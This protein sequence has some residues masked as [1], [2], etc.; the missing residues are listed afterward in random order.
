M[1]EERRRG[2]AGP[3]FGDGRG[4]L[5]LGIQ[6]FREI[7]ESGAYYVDKTAYAHR[8]ITEGK[9]YF[10]SRPRRFGK[11]LL[12]DMLRELFEG[13]EELFEGLSIHRR[14]DW[15]VRRPVVHLDFSAGQ[16]AKPDG[17]L[18][19]ANAQL[20]RIEKQTGVTTDY[21]GAPERFV[22]LL[23]E[24]HHQTGRRVVVLVDEYDQPILDTLNMPE[25]ARANRDFLRGFYAAVK[26]ADRHVRFVLLTGVSKFLKVSLFSGLNNLEDITLDPSYSVICG[27]TESDLDRVFATELEGL[28]RERV[29]EW[30]NGYSWLGSEKVYNPYDVL[31]LMRTR[32]FGSYWFETG[33]PRFLIDTLIRRRVPTPSLARVLASERLLSTFDVDYIGTEALLF[34]SG[35]LTITGTERRG[36]RTLYRL[37]Y[38]NLEV[39]QSLNESLL[40]RLAGADV[41]RTAS[42]GALPDILRDGDARGLRELFD[43]FFAGIPH[44]WHTSGRASRYEA[45]YASVFYTYFAACGLDVI[46]EDSTS[47]GRVD[48][49]VRT[50]RW[51][52]LFEFKTTSVLSG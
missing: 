38:P 30:Y 51:I 9:G 45:Y 35:Y 32:R 37:D 3:L 16:F 19:S 27:F 21:G 7:R 24:L 39:R 52:W 50:P 48:M 10:L 2:A 23:E 18:V 47:A 25:A 42:A 36:N 44:Q 29:R 5:P 26:S 46:V 4:R 34:Q 20:G 28:D 12:V 11:S 41:L 33:S 13:A 6:T 40:E 15:S 17:V 14:W 49:T 1:S 31:R 22:Q 8:M 43:S